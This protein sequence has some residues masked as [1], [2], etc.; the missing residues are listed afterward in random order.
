MCWY[1]H[2][3]IAAV[4]SDDSYEVSLP[5]GSMSTI[6]PGFNTKIPEPLDTIIFP[7]IAIG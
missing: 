2:I 5:R 6:L 3:L 7:G 1:H 4:E